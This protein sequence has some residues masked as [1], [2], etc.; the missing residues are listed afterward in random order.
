MFQS[1]QHSPCA[2]KQ[3]ALKGWSWLTSTTVSRTTWT[4]SNLHITLTDPQIHTAFSQLDKMNTYMRM[5]FI[6]YSSAFNTIVPPSELITWRGDYSP[7]V[8][9]VHPRLR[10]RT[11]SNTIIKFADDSMVV[12]LINDETAYRDE[13]SDLAVWDQDN[14][15]SSNVSKT[16]S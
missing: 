5:L 15:F 3:N 10:G 13:V 12:G 14:N 16:K 1:D 7:P 9:P 11:Y 6:D 2:Q 8:L 4:H